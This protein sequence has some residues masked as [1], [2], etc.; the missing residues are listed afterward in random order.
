MCYISAQN[1]TINQKSISARTEVIVPVNDQIDEDSIA[2]NTEIEKG[3]FIANTIMPVNNSEDV[4][5]K[6]FN[7]E[8]DTLRK[9]KG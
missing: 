2:L 6:D 1:D 4:G 3:V 9:Y 5:I 8:I 7:V